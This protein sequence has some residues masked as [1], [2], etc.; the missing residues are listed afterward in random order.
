[1]TPRLRLFS[2]IW[3]WIKRVLRDLWDILV[4]VDLSEVAE[5]HVIV[6]AIEGELASFDKEKLTPDRIAWAIARAVQARKG[7]ALWIDVTGE[8]DQGLA[9]EIWRPIKKLSLDALVGSKSF[10]A[11]L[12]WTVAQQGNTIVSVG[13]GAFH[14]YSGNYFKDWRPGI[15]ASIKF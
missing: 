6:S 12:G 3:N 15:V 13:A 2:R 7:A 14:E 10:G 4:N 9:I 5:D 1:M 11:A 8:A